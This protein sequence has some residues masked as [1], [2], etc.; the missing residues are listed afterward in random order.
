MVVGYLR[1]TL[2]AGE[3]FDKVCEL[4]VFAVIVVASEEESR[5]ELWSPFNLVI[6]IVDNRG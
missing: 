5:L 2:E 3:S 6:D 1:R 4:L